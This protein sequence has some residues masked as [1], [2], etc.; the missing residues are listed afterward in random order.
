MKVISS[1]VKYSH[2]LIG[3]VMMSSHVHAAISLDRTRVIYD[4]SKSSISLTVTNQNKSLPYLAQSWIE[5]ANGKKIDA[6]MTALP[7]IQRVE[8]GSKGQIKIQTT[9]NIAG[10][11]KDRESLFYFNV[12]EIPPKST[13]PNT[14]QLALQTR[15]KLFYRPA[16]ISIE[17]GAENDHMKLLTLQRLGG[18]YQLRNPTPYF[19]TVVDTGNDHGGTFKPVMV[20]PNSSA[21]LGISTK[22]A[23]SHPILTMVNDFGGRPQVNFTCSDNCTVASIKAG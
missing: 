13:K 10:L 6:P 18:G 3:L 2:C 5:D 17:R 8:P 23:G 21:S 19:I 22:M 14:L 15:V 12:R 1:S 7:P 11:P 16:S 9:G 4:G 20:A